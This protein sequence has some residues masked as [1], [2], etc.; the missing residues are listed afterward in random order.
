MNE[1]NTIIYNSLKSS[2]FNAP[3]ASDMAGYLL[4][5]L[6]R[7][8]PTNLAGLKKD[9]DDVIKALEAYKASI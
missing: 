2:G 3:C 1:F 9:I 8:E 6:S 4:S 5:C 7:P